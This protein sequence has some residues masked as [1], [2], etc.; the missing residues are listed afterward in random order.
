ME[1]DSNQQSNTSSTRRSTPRPVADGMVRPSTYS[2][3]RSVTR[4]PVRASSSAMEPTTTTSSPSS[5]IQM[6]SGVPQNRLRLTAQS[7]ASRSQLAKRP[8]FTDSGTHAVLSLAASSRSLM[9][10]TRTNQ[11][12]TAR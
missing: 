9:A 8:T 3:C 1:P 7:R 11:E 6:G 12:G 5:E 10:S 4:T 2:R